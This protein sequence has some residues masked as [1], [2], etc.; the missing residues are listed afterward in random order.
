MEEMNIISTDEKKKKW[1]FGKIACLLWF[2][3]QL[4]FA[5]AYFLGVFSGMNESVS[6]LTVVFKVLDFFSCSTSLW[7]YY[8]SSLTQAVL[9]LAVT[10]AIAKS[11]LRAFKRFKNKAEQNRNAYLRSEFFKPF[12]TAYSI[13]YSLIPFPKRNCRAEGLLY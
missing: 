4:G 2:F 8:L 5:V 11:L 6:V 3:A 1:S 7:Y 9:Y 10:V 12:I 13:S